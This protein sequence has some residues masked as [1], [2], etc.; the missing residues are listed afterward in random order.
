MDDQAWAAYVQT[1]WA[2]LLAR[3]EPGAVITRP[4]RRTL[5]GN[6]GCPDGLRYEWREIFT[7]REIL[8]EQQEELG[9]LLA[10]VREAKRLFEK[11][12]A[13]ILDDAE[14]AMGAA[15]DSIGHLVE[16]MEA[17]A[18]AFEAEIDRLEADG[19]DRDAED[20]AARAAR[21]AAHETAYE[22]AL[23]ACRE[24]V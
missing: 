9:K 14:A 3:P 10:H 22:D 8:F 1:A 24:R 12:P 15:S 6:P 16:K 13:F 7:R 20:D 19:I 2:A 18:A 17:C 4:M 21:I 11:M 5:W 23:A